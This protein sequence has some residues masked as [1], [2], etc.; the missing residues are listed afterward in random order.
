[1]TVFDDVEPADRSHLLCTA[2]KSLIWNADVVDMLFWIEITFSDRADVTRFLKKSTNQI[3]VV[4]DW[5]L[6]GWGG[7]GGAWG[8]MRH[9]EAE[10]QNNSTFAQSGPITCNQRTNAR[11]HHAEREIIW[12]HL[13][14]EYEVCS[15]KL[16]SETGGHKQT[17]QPRK[18]QLSAKGKA[19]TG[20]RWGLHCCLPEDRR[21]QL[22]WTSELSHCYVPCCWLLQMNCFH[23]WLTW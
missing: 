21:N 18:E 3:K 15:H 4:C 1:M 22:S 5:R 19:E 9:N 12:A 11:A 20:Q 7:D 13:E 16:A 2:A 14:S 8:T 23:Y 10:W 17:W 6:L